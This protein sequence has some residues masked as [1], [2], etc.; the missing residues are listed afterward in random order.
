[1]TPGAIP[2]GKRAV[3]SSRSWRSRTATATRTPRRTRCSPPQ[4]CWSP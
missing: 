4:A 2:E 1:V 3:W